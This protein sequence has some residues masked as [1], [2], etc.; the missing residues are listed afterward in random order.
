MLSVSLGVSES[1]SMS[2]HAGI[3]TDNT[4]EVIHYSAQLCG[5]VIPLEVWKFES[6]SVIRQV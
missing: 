5:P 1:D 3:E 6:P 4:S 2:T